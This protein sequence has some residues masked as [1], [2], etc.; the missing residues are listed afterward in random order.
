LE[1]SKLRSPRGRLLRRRRAWEGVIQAPARKAGRP[2]AKQAGQLGDAIVHAALRVFRREGFAAAT[3]E[4]IAQEAGTTRRSVTHRFPDKNGLL[5]A[6]FEFW[7]GEHRQ[8][9]FTP[10]SVLAGHPIDAVRHA[11]RATFD[12]AC[13]EDFVAFYRLA[14]AV[15]EQNPVVGEVLIRLNDRF[16]AELEA[17]VMRAQRVGLFA[18]QDPA[19]TAT[20]LIG[21]FL[22]NPL[23]RRALGDVQFQDAERQDRYFEALW[24]LVAHASN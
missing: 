1:A 14:M 11:C 12:N 19:D 4:M 6:V 2:T 5:I 7:A 22:S 15:A 10:A 18:G 8:R 16:A 20:A 13:V 17:L 3:I 24:A 9:V 21:V 23:N